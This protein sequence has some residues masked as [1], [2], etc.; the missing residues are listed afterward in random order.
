M[1][2]SEEGLNSFIRHPPSFHLWLS[3][4]CAV[5]CVC[6]YIYTTKKRKYKTFLYE[7]SIVLLHLVAKIKGKYLSWNKKGLYFSHL[8]GYTILFLKI[9]IGFVKM[10]TKSTYCIFFVL[11]AIKDDLII[12]SPVLAVV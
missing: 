5:A 1:L 10:K 7:Y 2:G 3:C 8:L 6:I 4:I 9:F 12:G 11:Y